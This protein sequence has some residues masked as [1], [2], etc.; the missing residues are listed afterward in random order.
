MN[1]GRFYRK[2]NISMC[3]EEKE[4]NEHLIPT[5]NIRLKKKKI[6]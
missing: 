3:I 2:L 1:E 4:V 6:K 5:R